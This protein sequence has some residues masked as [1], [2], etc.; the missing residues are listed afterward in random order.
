MK[1][2]TPEWRTGCHLHFHDTDSAYSKG[3]RCPAARDAQR[4]SKKRRRENRSAPK[5]IPALPT[6]RRLQALAALGWSLSEVAVRLDVSDKTISN[7]R[8]GAWT[9][10][11]PATAR[12]VSALYDEL[13]GTPG[14]SLSTRIRATKRGWA[15]PLAWNDI[16]RDAHP[17]VTGLTD[18]C[19]RR[20]ELIQEMHDL[21]RSAFEI[22]AR[23]NVRPDSLERRA[24]YAGRPE[25]ARALHA[26]VQQHTR[27][28]TA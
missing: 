14:P 1:A 5:L 9:N 27:R 8:A 2:Y 18:R 11:Y 28:A 16:S 17:V 4:I 15:P 7:L 3:C 25:L 26:Q 12:R 23:L 22:A 13:Q 10:V 20:V 24:W 6:V 21:G 19:A